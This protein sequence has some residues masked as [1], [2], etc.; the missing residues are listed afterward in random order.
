MDHAR[1]VGGKMTYSGAIVKGDCYEGLCKAF[2]ER[3]RG[4]G[5][6][7]GEREGGGSTIIIIVRTV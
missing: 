4:D 1:L 3:G 6:M 7:E 5:G 2:G